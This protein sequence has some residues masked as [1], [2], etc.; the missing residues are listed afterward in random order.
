MYNV[1]VSV[2]SNAVAAASR[3]RD[4]SNDTNSERL[5]NIWWSKEREEWRREKDT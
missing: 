3:A 5:G 1:P 2:L 4:A